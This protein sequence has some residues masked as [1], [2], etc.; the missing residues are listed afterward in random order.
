MEFIYFITWLLLSAAVA[1]F[2]SNKG[3]S[4]TAYFFISLFC[5]PLLGLIFAALASPSAKGIERNQLA[6]GMMQKCPFCAEVIKKEA[7]VCRYCGKD[8]S[9][10]LLNRKPNQIPPIV[11]QSRPVAKKPTQAYKV[12][13]DGEEYAVLNTD[14]IKDLIRIQ[15]LTLDDYYLD[16]TSNSWIPLRQHPNI[17]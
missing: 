1:G 5:S 6:S 13:K 15:E 17:S 3:N 11:V 7:S 2:A 10:A 12:A 14:E 16:S 8:L 4:G 9:P